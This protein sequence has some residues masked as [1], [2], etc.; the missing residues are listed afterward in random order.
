MG[1]CLS[2]HTQS[3]LVALGRHDGPSRHS[4]RLKP[5][6]RRIRSTT[7][8]ANACTGGRR[9]SPYLIREQPIA[10]CEYAKSTSDPQAAFLAD[11]TGGI[12]AGG[13]RKKES[14]LPSAFVRSM[15]RT[16]RRTRCIRS[17]HGTLLQWHRALF[18]GARLR[19][20]GR[21]YFPA[22]RE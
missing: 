3:C 9:C 16:L 10:L 19:H 20:R 22:V 8:S 18:H 6:C 21:L 11:R 13:P 7:Q 17:R 14:R 2:P 12:P 5:R 1:Y 4:G 15:R